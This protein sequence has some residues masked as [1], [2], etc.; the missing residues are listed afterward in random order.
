MKFT[1]RV[2]SKVKILGK[3][4]VTMPRLPKYKKRMKVKLGKGKKNIL[5]HS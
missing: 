3:R 2:K 5:D 1:K 4:K